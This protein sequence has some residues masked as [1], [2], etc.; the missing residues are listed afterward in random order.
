MIGPLATAASAEANPLCWALTLVAPVNGESR[1]RYDMRPKKF[2]V[3]L[4][5]IAA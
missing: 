4:D 1:D 5:L 2:R 3:C